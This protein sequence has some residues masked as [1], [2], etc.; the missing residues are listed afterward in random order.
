MSYT[1]SLM[2]ACLAFSALPVVSGYGQGREDFSGLTQN[3][4][5]ALPADNRFVVLPFPPLNDVVL[6]RN[7]GLLWE[8]LPSEMGT[9]WASAKA[10]CINKAVGGQKGWRLPSIAELASL[11]DPSI[12]FPG[13]TLPPR[14]P[15]GTVQ[16]TFY[17]S[18]STDAS[19]PN[20]AWVV[21]FAEGSVFPIN[22][23]HEIFLAWC[24]RGPMQQSVY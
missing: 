1:K 19:D 2:L 10:N 15:F 21:A 22:K 17:W 11:I 3:W 23:L 20:H 24:V 6:D 13:P 8:K 12:T 14:N 5:Q 7:T 16:S 4:D 9:T 18:A